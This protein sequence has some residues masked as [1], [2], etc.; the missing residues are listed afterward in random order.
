[1]NLPDTNVFWVS[2]DATELFV[3]SEIASELRVFTFFI[4]IYKNFG[5]NF[6]FF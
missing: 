6:L 4:K 1:M 5:N 2:V 3:F